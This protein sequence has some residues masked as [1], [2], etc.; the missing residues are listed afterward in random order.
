MLFGLGWLLL[1]LVGFLLPFMRFLLGGTRLLL[2]RLLGA[3]CCLGRV[4]G[5]R[6]LLLLC[7]FTWGF[8][9]GGRLCSSGFCLGVG[10]LDGGRLLGP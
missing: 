10:V 7:L 2:P 9:W 4:G 3:W 1:W 5:F 8:L 6:F